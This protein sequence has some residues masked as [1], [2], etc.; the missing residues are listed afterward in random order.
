[1]TYS[2][3]P[4]NRKKLIEEANKGSLTALMQDQTLTTEQK[5]ELV[6]ERNP[7]IYALG[8]KLK[9]QKGNEEYADWINRL[10]IGEAR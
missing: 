8:D 1:M 2:F 9:P 4:R 5:R 3:K 10:Y 6:A 7:F